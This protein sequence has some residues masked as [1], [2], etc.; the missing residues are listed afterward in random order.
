M[1]ESLSTALG[2]LIARTLAE[3]LPR[4]TVPDR[5]RLGNPK[6]LALKDTQTS[7]LSRLSR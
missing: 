3:F 6:A 4:T 2:S 5:T 7:K 1:S